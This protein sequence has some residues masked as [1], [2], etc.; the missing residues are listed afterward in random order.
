[1]KNRACRIRLGLFYQNRLLV[2]PGIWQQCF[3]RASQS[4][5]LC[6][7]AEKRRARTARV[8]S[9]DYRNISFLVPNVSAFVAVDVYRLL[10][11]TS[12]Q[13]PKRWLLLVFL[14]RTVINW[15]S[16]CWW[17]SSLLFQDWDII[18]TWIFWILDERKV[19]D[20][21]FWTPDACSSP[22][23]KYDTT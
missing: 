20:F 6:R 1:M 23:W 16:K 4:A 3:R 12:F 14:C 5:R 19:L 17:T 11:L 15:V 10:P 9:M 2:S 21:S 22:A 7:A 18:F 8:V 13:W